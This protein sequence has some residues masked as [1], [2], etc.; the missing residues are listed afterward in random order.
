MDIKTALEEISAL[1]FTDQQI[2]D[3]VGCAQSIITRLRRGE[4]K[5]TSYERGQ[6]IMRL[7]KKATKKA[8]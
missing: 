6:K 4:H 5:S 7:H 8:A 2:G 1:G 3:E